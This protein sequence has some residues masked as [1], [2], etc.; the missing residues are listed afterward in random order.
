MYKVFLF[1]AIVFITSCSNG[2]GWVH[3]P[4]NP[5]NKEDL[6]TLNNS[7]LLHYDSLF[8][9]RVNKRNEI[10][11]DKAEKKRDILMELLFPNDIYFS[12]Y[13]KYVLYI[14]FSNPKGNHFMYMGKIQKHIYMKNYPYVG[15]IECPDITIMDLTDSIEYYWSA[16]KDDNPFRFH[17]NKITVI[18]SSHSAHP[19]YKQGRMSDE[20]QTIMNMQPDYIEELRTNP[21]ILYKEYVDSIHQVK[22]S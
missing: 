13:N 18:L 12:P 1:L 20:E 10:G 6:D 5:F 15:N 3:S 16:S 14:T 11:L 19:I 2:K 9:W 22:E 21:N 4:I 8:Y 17:G 7:P